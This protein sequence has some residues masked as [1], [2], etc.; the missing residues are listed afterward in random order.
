MISKHT[1]YKFESYQHFKPNLT[2]ELVR[3]PNIGFVTSLSASNYF[4]AWKCIKITNISTMVE[5]GIPSSYP[6]FYLYEQVSVQTIQETVYLCYQ[7][8]SPI[9][10]LIRL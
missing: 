7:F 9:K 6:G 3:F 2:E 5:L 4:K 1:Y 8:L 10:S